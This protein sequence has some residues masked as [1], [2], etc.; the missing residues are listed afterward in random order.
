MKKRFIFVM[1]L[2]VLFTITLCGCTSSTKATET[3]KLLVDYSFFKTENSEEYLN[4][5]NEID[6]SNTQEIVAISNSSYV[7]EHTGPFNV[8]TVTYK[9]CEDT[10]DTNTKY[11]YSLFETENEQ[12]YLLFLD[13]LSDKYEIVDISTGTYAFQ[14]TGP[15]NTFI[16]TYRK[17]L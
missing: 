7:H 11:E 12:E 8:Y 2:L 16:I 14:Y 10:K 4:F 6:N 5:L 1:C 9:V 3:P 15:Y 17:P 13:A